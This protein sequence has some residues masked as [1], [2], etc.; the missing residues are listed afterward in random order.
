MNRQLGHLLFRMRSWLP[1][2]WLLPLL[3]FGNW[4]YFDWILGMF[5]GITGMSIRLW[6]V[7]WIGSG[8]RRRDTGRPEL[9]VR[10]P[11]KLIRNPLYVAN[12]SIY[13]GLCMAGAMHYLAV[14]VL[15]YSCIYYH[16]IVHFE[17][18][19]WSNDETYQ[20]YTQRVSRWFPQGSFRS[21]LEFGPLHAAFR[22]ERSTILA[23]TGCMLCLWIKGVGLN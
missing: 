22:S 1:I 9:C 7:S 4:Q 13:V 20:S 17:E 11:Y 18:S 6:A 12:V 16:F 23:W 14:G 21:A 15:F 8:S 3:I 5:I 10:G 2:P 19:I